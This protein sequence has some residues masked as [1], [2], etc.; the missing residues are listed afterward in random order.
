MHFVKTILLF[1]HN[2]Y[3]KYLY[4]VTFRLSCTLEYRGTCIVRIFNQQTSI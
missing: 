1:V 3:I 4:V 2:E